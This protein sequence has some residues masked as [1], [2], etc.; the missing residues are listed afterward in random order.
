ME[1]K[2]CVDFQFFEVAKS[3]FDFFPSDSSTGADIS[4]RWASIYRF[5]KSLSSI[6]RLI[7]QSDSRDAVK[8]EITPIQEITHGKTDCYY[9][10]ALHLF[11]VDCSFRRRGKNVTSRGSFQRVIV[12]LSEHMLPTP[13]NQVQS[14][15]LSSNI[16]MVS[17]TFSPTYS[18]HIDFEI[19]LLPI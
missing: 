19:T 17:H 5:S 3:D 16:K 6:P 1:F 7:S 15:P 9:V 2:M 4:S 13:K 10:E 12:I 8:H 14:R 11:L 18:I